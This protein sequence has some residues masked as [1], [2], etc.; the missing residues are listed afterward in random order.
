MLRSLHPCSHISELELCILECGDRFSELLSFLYEVDATV[1]RALAKTESLSGYTDTS[2][3]KG[4]HSL[5]EALAPCSKHVFLR[6][7]A[8]LE[9]E[10]VG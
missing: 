5:I 10:F 6:Y 1:D 4:M 7:P 2:T 3:V 8:V 9:N